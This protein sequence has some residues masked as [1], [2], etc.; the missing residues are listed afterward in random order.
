M[1]NFEEQYT[2]GTCASKDMHPYG[3]IG[4]SQPI[5]AFLQW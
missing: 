5:S 4:S 1:L 2:Y 3:N